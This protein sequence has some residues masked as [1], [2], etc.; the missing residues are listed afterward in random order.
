M[1]TVSKVGLV[2]VTY[3]SA[4]VI[5]AFLQ[6]VRRQTHEAITLYV[7]DNLS[8]DG[9]LSRIPGSDALPAVVIANDHNAGVAEGNNQGIRAA[10]ADGC[11]AVLLIN[12][13]TEFGP[14]LVATLC[15]EL[16]RSG[17]DMIVPKIMYFEPSDTIWC[18]GGTFRFRR[19]YSG[20]HYGLGELD[21]GQYDRL[22]QVEYSPT[23]CMLVRREVFDRIGE[24]DPKY[25]VYFDDTDFCFRAWKA[26]LRLVYTPET[27]LYHKVSAL[28]GGAE[29]P[30]SIR[31]TTRNHVYFLLKN[32]GV[33]G[34]AFFLPAYFG[35]ICFKQLMAR[36]SR[37]SSLIARRG[38]VEGLS[39]YR[40]LRGGR[41]C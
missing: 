41:T 15:S 32:L 18:A 2:T 33:L 36:Q 24:M 22:R 31:Y 16:S 3:N 30:F 10:L 4:T 5:D 17:A 20:E 29:T 26:G 9:T 21:T 11:D 34:G 37:E 39:L 28:T 40:H 1:R 27:V 12:N 38:F 13:D 7:V 25:F 35:K 8:S 6:S 23:C 14:E 19:G